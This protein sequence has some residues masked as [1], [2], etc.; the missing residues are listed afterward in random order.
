[1]VD[2]RRPGTRISEVLRSFGIQ[3]HFGCGCTSLAR[4]MDKVGP[5]KVLEDLD[6]YTSKMYESI[7]NWRKG[8]RMPIPQPP[9]FVVK[10]FIEWACS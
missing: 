8:N 7:K 4:E 1:M 2:R 6:S 5:D 10:K 3:P 9:L